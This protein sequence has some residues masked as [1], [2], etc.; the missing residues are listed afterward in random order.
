VGPTYF[1]G[2]VSDWRALLALRVETPLAR[3]EPHP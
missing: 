1:I 2:E 3:G